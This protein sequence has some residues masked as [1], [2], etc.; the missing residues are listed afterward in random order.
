[1]TGQRGFAGSAA[2]TC[3]RAGGRA[4][5]VGRLSGR[6]EMQAGEREGSGREKR[7]M[8]SSLPTDARTRG[9]DNDA[10]AWA[11]MAGAWVASRRGSSLVARAPN[12][13]CIGCEG[14]MRDGGRNVEA[15]PP[16][17]HA[18]VGRVSHGST[19]SDPVRRRCRTERIKRR[20]TYPSMDRRKLAAILS[21]KP[22]LLNAVGPCVEW[23]PALRKIGQVGG[24]PHYVAI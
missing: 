12:A 23:G 24:V 13:R 11:P 16:A 8:P 5:S 2:T 19:P 9:C 15:Y 10:M 18:R 3:A 14:M 4:R 1:M 6:G 21:F 22:T 7:G 20:R 17:Q